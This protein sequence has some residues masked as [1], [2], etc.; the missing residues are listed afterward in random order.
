MEFY[1]MNLLQPSRND[2]Q[3][4]TLSMAWLPAL[5]GLTVICM[6][7]TAVMSGAN[8]SRWLLEICHSLWGQTEGQSL[9][10]ANILLRKFGHFCGY[11][12]LS[13]LFRRGWCYSLGLKWKGSRS[14]LPF[15]AT[16]LAVI[17]TFSVACLDEL[18]QRFL[19]GRTSSFYDVLIDTTGAIVFNRILMLVLA[20]RRKRLLESSNALDVLR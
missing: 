20:K 10:T 1:P 9:E 11:G 5:L 12:T 6:E 14:R 2:A 15:S 3:Q 17:C 8:T 18:H 13:L 4:S 19:P 7:S 16:A